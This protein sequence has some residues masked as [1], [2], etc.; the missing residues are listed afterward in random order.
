M[1]RSS[2]E[3]LARDP[4]SE[5]AIGLSFDGRPH[6]APMATLEDVEDLALARAADVL[7]LDRADGHAVFAGG[8]RLFESELEPA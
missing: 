1:S 4:P 5:V 7:D 8:E 3:S 2:A 6:T